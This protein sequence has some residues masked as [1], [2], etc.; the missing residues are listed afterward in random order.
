[1]GAKLTQELE[2]NLFDSILKQLLSALRRAMIFITQASFTWLHSMALF[3][4][5]RNALHSLAVGLSFHNVH[6]FASGKV[7]RRTGLD[8]P[9]AIDC[10]GL[11]VDFG[12]HI[13]QALAIHMAIR[14]TLLYAKYTLYI[15]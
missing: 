13:S 8:V 15:I 14:F 3:V 1:M 7:M 9:Q 10:K 12:T 4:M 6:C 11:T 2:I 5:L